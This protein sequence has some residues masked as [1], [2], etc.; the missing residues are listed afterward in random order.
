[1]DA[2]LQLRRR[3]WLEQAL[4]QGR[5][6]PEVAR[7]TG[8][9]ESTLRGWLRPL[10]ST[11]ATCPDCNGPMRH[12]AADRCRGCEAL[13]RRVWTHL[14]I[15]EARERWGA[16]FGRPPTT[17]DWNPSHARRHG[18]WQAGR[19]PSTSTVVRRFG[20]WH[21]FLTAPLRGPGDK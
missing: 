19:W 14:A 13:R 7:L 11:A 17:Y 9:P 6:L 20:S 10:S 21:A 8:L 18:R 5:S 15:L 1:M 2:G 4:D 16:E 12:P 3:R